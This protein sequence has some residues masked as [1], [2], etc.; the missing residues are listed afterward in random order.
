MYSKKQ[1]VDYFFYCLLHFRKEVE[2]EALLNQLHRQRKSTKRGEENRK[3][4]R[5]RK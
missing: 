5:K 1:T 2:R 4:K 3:R